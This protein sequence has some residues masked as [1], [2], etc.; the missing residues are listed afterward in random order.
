[1]EFLQVTTVT[2]TLDNNHKKYMYIEMIAG[3]NYTLTTA[4]QILKGGKTEEKIGSLR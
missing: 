4:T 3:N 2:H 1:M